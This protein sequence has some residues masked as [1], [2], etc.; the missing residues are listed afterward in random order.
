M[1][2]ITSGE[3][4][5]RRHRDQPPLDDAV[6]PGQHCHA[7]ARRSW[8][9]TRRRSG[10]RT[11]PT[12]PALVRR[13]YRDGHWAVPQG[14]VSAAAGGRVMMDGFVAAVSA[15]ELRRSRRLVIARNECSC[16]H[17]SGRDDCACG[18][19]ALLLA[20]A[21]AG[22]ARVGPGRGPAKYVIQISV[23]GLGSSYLQALLDEGRAADVQ[24]AAARRG[25]HAQRPHRFR[26]HHH[27]AQPHLHGHWPAGA[28]QGRPSPTAIAGHHVDDQHR[29]GRARR[30]TATATTTCQHVRRG[31]RQRAA[32]R[33]CSPPRASSSLYDQSYDERNGAPDTTGEDNGRDKID[34]YVKEGMRAR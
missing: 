5:Q 29:S 28:R 34:L 17:A 19:V 18:T 15:C 21:G 16:M 9:S 2:C 8:S 12:R 25:L 10:S 4:P 24:A 3:R 1:E 33:A 13:Q 14:R 27:A 6:P 32:D 31:P 7:R 11:M 20:I 22:S 30:C 23:D 26:L